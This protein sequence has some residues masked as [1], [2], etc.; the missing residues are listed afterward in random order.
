MQLLALDMGQDKALSELSDL[1]LL[2]KAKEGNRRAFEVLFKRHYTSVRR[3]V[4]S[5][6]GPC[7]DV[8]DVVQ[9][10]FLRVYRTAMNFQGKSKFTSWLF[11]VAVNMTYDHMRQK[12]RSGQLIEHWLEKHPEP[13][14]ST[15]PLDNSLNRE[16]VKKVSE[17]LD[18]LKV[19][20]RNV[21]I[22]FEIQGLTLD[23]IAKTLD[24]STTTVWSR[25]YQARKD[26]K[27]FYEK[28]K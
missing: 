11:R 27:K 25:L 28:A 15:T 21:F 22:L 10:V 24:L 20:K 7:D 3:I 16:E 5:V 19:H 12:K 13:A 26:F 2:E 14:P 8:E 23:E 6:I 17:A 1:G 4:I 9:N 18:K